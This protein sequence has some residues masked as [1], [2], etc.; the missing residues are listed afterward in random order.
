MTDSSPPAPN[1]LLRTADDSPYEPCGR[2]I[3]K[4]EGSENT[5]EA[6]R[7]PEPDSNIEITEDPK[8]DCWRVTGRVR[9]AFTQKYQPLQDLNLSEVA[10]ELQTILNNEPDAEQYT[11]YVEMEGSGRFVLDVPKDELPQITGYWRINYRF[12]ID[13]NYVTSNMHFGNWELNNDETIDLP[14]VHNLL[15]TSP[16][17]NV[18]ELGVLDLNLVTAVYLEDYD[19]QIIHG[20]IMHESDVPVANWPDPIL[21]NLD[22]YV[23][24]HTGSRIAFDNSNRNISTDVDGYFLKFDGWDVPN[25][26]LPASGRWALHDDRYNDDENVDSLASCGNPSFKDGAWDFGIFQVKDCLVEVVFKGDIENLRETQFIQLTSLHSDFDVNLRLPSGR[27]ILPEGSYNWTSLSSGW[28]HKYELVKGQ[29]DIVDKSLNTIILQVVEKPTFHIRPML[30]WPKKG[31]PRNTD[32]VNCQYEGADCKGAAEVSSGDIVIVPADNGVL[33]VTV[34]ATGFIPQTLDVDPKAGTLIVTLQP[35]PYIEVLLHLPKKPDN[36]AEWSMDVW[37]LVQNHKDRKSSK[38]YKDFSLTDDPQTVSIFFKKAEEYSFCL[39]GK[40]SWG[41]ESYSDK[42]E[43]V[44]CNLRADSINE[45]T[46]PDMLEPTWAWQAYKEKYHLT[47]GSQRA[48]LSGKFATRYGKQG[49]HYEI[50]DGDSKPVFDARSIIGIYDGDEIHDAEL[51]PPTKQD[52]NIHISFGLPCRISATARQ[53]GKFIE[54]LT[55]TA[56]TEQRKPHYRCSV[57]VKDGKGMLWLPE[58]QAEVRASYMNRLVTAT[59]DVVKGSVVDVVLQFDS[60]LVTFTESNTGRGEDCKLFKKRSDGHFEYIWSIDAGDSELLDGGHY[61]LF[62]MYG[63]EK[64]EFDITEDSPSFSVSLPNP[65]QQYTSG[66]ITIANNVIKKATGDD[67]EYDLYYKIVTGNPLFDMNPDFLVEYIT[68]HDA[69][70][71]LVLEDIPIGAKICLLGNVFVD[72]EDG[73]TIKCLKP[74]VVTTTRKHEVITVSWMDARSVDWQ[75][76]LALGSSTEGIALGLEYVPVGRHEFVF[77]DD[78]G[79]I[80]LREW[81]SIPDGEDYFYLPEA[82]TNHL[83]E[84]RSAND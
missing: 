39:V 17:G 41:F 72:N 12:N 21:V 48:S 9:N 24:E 81:I 37:V 63:S 57:K 78:E 2:A 49:K 33:T 42:T 16:S 6:G 62:N 44:L 34:S 82:I 69:K 28:L 43:K 20:R 22:E 4:P 7:Y 10:I 61:V 64:V 58:G 60:C 59:I 76:V 51:T 46:L 8:H 31:P 80:I 40:D 54:N 70:Q 73:Y 50:A 55:F 71:E 68:I 52:R 79:R 65:A 66:T 25:L 18:L 74:V 30:N 29:I 38:V 5:V 23:E 3:N 84:L 11:F 75:V 56:V 53:G 13:G 45:V 35:I 47:I 1:T 32:D 67:I 77:Y 19:N 36:V 15:E 14:N 83:A 26:T 27:F